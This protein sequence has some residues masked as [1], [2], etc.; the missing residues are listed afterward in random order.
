MRKEKSV[1]LSLP[2]LLALCILAFI[3]CFAIKSATPLI[4]YANPGGYWFKQLIFYF[5]SFGLLFFVYKFGNDR[6]YSAMW[7]IYGVLM[8]FLVGLAV[9]RICITRFGFHVIPLAKTNNGAT[10]WY[11]FPGFDFQPSEFMK[12]ALIVVLAK[13]IYTHNNKYLVHNFHN[14][15]LMLAK[16][17]GLSLPP[18]ILIYMQNDAGVTLI[19]LVSVVFILF[20]SG[21]QAR[22]FVVGAIVV[23]TI[24]AIGTYL[25]IFQ[26]EVFSNILGGGYKLGRFYGWVNP[27]GTYGDEG[28]QLF[29]ALMAYGTGGWFG[30]GFGSN[31]ISFPEAQT[32]FIF[33]VIAQGFGFVGGIITIISIAFFDG[34]LLKIGLRT[35]NERD[36]YY[37]A[38]IFG[39]LIFQ[40]IWN[41]GMVMG[42]VPITGIT[43]PL[44]S[45]GGSSLLSYMIAMGIFLDIEKQT[46]VTERKNRYIL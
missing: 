39:M 24:L 5:L 44:I 46:R 36:K 11:Q 13:V 6:I 10:S 28:Y 20:V 2:L 33:A 37:V 43:L 16:V 3:S 12:V 7:I 8:V 17:L 32:D 4:Q 25:F 38:G 42:L 21:L 31:I 1:L 29:N 40:Q 41:I 30:H 18:C 9:E 34:V 27:E 35:K 15:C 19:I 23:G 22:W 26:H 14:D 45:Y